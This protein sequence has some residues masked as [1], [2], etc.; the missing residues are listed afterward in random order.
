MFIPYKKAPHLSKGAL[1]WDR[2]SVLSS[3]IEKG[4]PD[5]ESN[6][7]ESISCEYQF[8]EICNNIQKAMNEEDAESTKFWFQQLFN[9]AYLN[10]ISDSLPSFIVPDILFI[11]ANENEEF[12]VDFRKL[13]VDVFFALL[14]CISDVSDF[15]TQCNAVPLLTFN[16]LN[17]DDLFPL[18]VTVLQCIKKISNHCINCQ[19]FVCN[20]IQDNNFHFFQKWLSDLEDN[21]NVNEIHIEIFSILK[22]I[23]KFTFDD[24]DYD[25]NDLVEDCFNIFTA[26]MDYSDDL[27][28]ISLLGLG[29]LINFQSRTDWYKLYEGSELQYKLPKYLAHKD[30][31]IK[32]S[33]LLVIASIYRQRQNVHSPNFGQIVDLL[34]YNDELNESNASAVRYYAAVAI[35]EIIKDNPDFIHLIVSAFYFLDAFEDIFDA[36]SFDVKCELIYSLE[37]VAI[38]GYPSEKFNLIKNGFIKYFVHIIDNGDKSQILRA[39]DSLDVLFSGDYKEM[40]YNYFYHS[41]NYKIV[42]DLSESP[43]NI[44]KER[45]C[46]FLNTHFPL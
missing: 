24:D 37:E 46:Q 13:A 22:N 1:K 44:I 12:D 9:Y 30:F 34:H 32:Q 2:F 41:P 27:L 16:I 8:L 4:M 39:I 33:A 31:T 35:N 45:A 18:H 26:F 3:D 43:D 7:A 28:K 11:I 21:Q 23:S 19:R 14:K 15:F 10:G 36:S 29:N 6:Q 5:G 42:F 25:D 20:C 40:C 38:N 17:D